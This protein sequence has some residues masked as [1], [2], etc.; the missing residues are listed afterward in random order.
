MNK[1]TQIA[2]AIFFGT[3]ATL[4]GAA[5]GRTIVNFNESFT[6]LF[7]FDDNKI[8]S[9][10]VRDVITDAGE[11]AAQNGKR[12]RVE[13]FADER[14]TTAYNVGLAKRRANTVAALLREG[15][16]DADSIDVTTYGE[17]PSVMLGEGHANAFG[18]GPGSG[19]ALDR[20]VTYHLYDTE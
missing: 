4:A 16:L 19:W 2:I 7:E 12:I 5:E 3:V 1:F 15:G 11:Y 8:L 14:G 9:Q 10:Q 20:R 13:A 17:D 18:V 6:V